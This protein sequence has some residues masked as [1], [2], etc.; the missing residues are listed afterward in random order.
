M[1]MQISCVIDT[2][3]LLLSMPIPSLV[4]KYYGSFLGSKMLVRSLSYLLVALAVG[5]Y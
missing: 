4:T 1:I 5:V 2:L 3:P